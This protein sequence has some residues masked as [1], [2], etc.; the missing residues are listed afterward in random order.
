[1]AGPTR[2]THA[3]YLSFL[4][5]HQHGESRLAPED[6]FSLYR[7]FIHSCVAAADG[8]SEPASPHPPYRTVPY[9][10]LLVS[11]PPSLD[12]SPRESLCSHSI[13]A[14]LS[15][16]HALS[17][18]YAVA[19]G[20]CTRHSAPRPA[21][22]RTAAGRAL[23][24]SSSAP[25][26]LP[27]Q[28]GPSCGFVYRAGPVEHRFSWAECYRAAAFIVDGCDVQMGSCDSHRWPCDADF[29]G[30]RPLYYIYHRDF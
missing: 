6:P 17:S 28:T 5:P 21:L 8:P 20:A 23:G 26:L 3:A 29:L 13:H 14:C 15:P 12:P 11:S 7:P 4:L 27:P 9:R 2:A 25:P 10:A 16:G 30:L 18:L 22:C 24:T 19:R 1:M